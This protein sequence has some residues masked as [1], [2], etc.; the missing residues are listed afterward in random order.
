MT[1]VVIDSNVI[2]AGIL[3]KNR[4]SPNRRLYDLVVSDLITAYTC[5]AL[6]GEIERVFQ[7]D[8]NIIERAKQINNRMAEVLRILGSLQ[9]PY[10]RSK[11]NAIFEH[12]NTVSTAHLTVDEGILKSLGIDWYLISIALAR[13]VDYIV[14]WEN[15]VIA[16]VNS[17]Y[18]HE[19]FKAVT[20]TDFHAKESQ[21]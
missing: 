15:A 1:S 9:E 17:K 20:P 6:R 4:R 21:W 10:V 12:M 19:G 5:D 14:T 2:I 18:A 11:L 16:M 7:N 13:K 8:G 3:T